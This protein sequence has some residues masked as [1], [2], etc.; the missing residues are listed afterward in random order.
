VPTFSLIFSPRLAKPSESSNLLGGFLN[1]IP[2]S[3]K[4][5]GSILMEVR[6]R[7]IYF[8]P[9]LGVYPLKFRPET[10]WPNGPAL[11]I[12]GRSVAEIPAIDLLDGIFD[13]M[14]TRDHL[15][16]DPCRF[17]RQQPCRM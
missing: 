3:A 11:A 8:W 16:V 9:F 6:K 1:G 7:T 2:T 10:P 17:I 12:Y 4:F 14:V 15:A 13:D 5:V